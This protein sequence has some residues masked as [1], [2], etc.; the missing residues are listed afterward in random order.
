M[1]NYLPSFLVIFSILSFLVLDLVLQ[2]HKLLEKQ[3]TNKTIY[4]NLNSKGKNKDVN[5]PYF[6]NK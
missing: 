3:N 1:T 4:I 2:V 5:L 6:L